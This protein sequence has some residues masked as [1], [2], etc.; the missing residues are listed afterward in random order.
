[1]RLLFGL[2]RLALYYDT[3]DA[4]NMEL[5][6]ITS[7]IVNEYMARELKEGSS[8][9]GA[10]HLSDEWS[11]WVAGGL[12]ACVAAAGG[13]CEPQLSPPP[14]AGPSGACSGLGGRAGI[15]KEI[16]FAS[17]WQCHAVEGASDG[18]CPSCLSPK[19]MTSWT[20]VGH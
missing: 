15:R 19:Q 17:A 1:M 14:T 7:E 8:L 2:G 4:R 12:A 9:A 10:D 3:Q 5:N 20:S 6:K 13:S 11:C 18:A 16:L